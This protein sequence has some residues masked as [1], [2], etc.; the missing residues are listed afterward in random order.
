MRFQIL[1]RN[2]IEKASGLVVVIDVLRAF[3]TA[4]YI[5]SKGA[6]EIVLAST[7]EEGLLLKKQYPKYLLVGERKGLKLT[8]YDYG[9]SPFEIKQASLLDKTVVMTTSLGT[10]TLLDLYTLSKGKEF[11]T[12]SFVNASAIINY[13]KKSKYEIVSLICTD[14]SF[15]DNEDY[16]C[17]KY[18]VSNFIGKSLDFQ[19]IKEDL[20]KHPISEGFL[21]KPLTKYAPDDFN[22]CLQVNKFRFIIMSN[23]SAE[24]ILLKPINYER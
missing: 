24:R 6:K 23:R 8:G 16:M 21:K 7:P 15:N 13:I 1:G 20:T 4:C 11:I 17:A 18:I 22:L 12:G 2:T 14:D 5:F 10:S 3:T 9:N 19:K